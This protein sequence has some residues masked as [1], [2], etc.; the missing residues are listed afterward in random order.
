MRRLFVVVCSMVFIN[1]LAHAQADGLRVAEYLVRAI[2]DSPEWVDNVDEIEN[3]AGEYRRYRNYE[4]LFLAE[5]PSNQVGAAW[6]PQERKIAFENFISAIPELSTNKMYRAIKVH[7]GIA[8]RFCRDHGATNILS[9]AMRILSSKHSVAQAG[10]MDV[11]REFAVPSA[12]I[13][14][15]VAN[16]LTNEAAM[17]IHRRSSLF[18]A[19]ID[20]LVRRRTECD[21]VA[22][23]NGISIVMSFVDGKANAIALDRLL[24]EVYS[25]YENSSNRLEIARRALNDR[26]LDELD[27]ES[28]VE[29]YFITVT[30]Q[31][32]NAV[33]PL[34][35]VNELRDLGVHMR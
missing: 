12:D 22:F 9:S 6:T 20:A 11:F 29:N 8:L 32:L 16:M 35:E 19:Y 33:H 17:I 3:V 21:P 5:F 25:S 7:A 34:C 27:E 4:D 13:N 23:T 2:M 14:A 18:D 10:A 30:N 26:C 28:V 31:L 24:K 1:F 15:F